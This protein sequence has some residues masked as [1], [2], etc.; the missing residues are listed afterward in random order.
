MDYTT[1]FAFIT[2]SRTI[3]ELYP[4]YLVVYIYTTLFGYNQIHPQ[5]PCLFILGYGSIPM[6][7]PF[8]GGWTSINPSYF[9]VNRRGTLGF[10]TLPV[11]LTTINHH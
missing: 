7:I 4:I 10:D 6:K 5:A 8:L 9:D 2:Q 1:I 3:L 11:D